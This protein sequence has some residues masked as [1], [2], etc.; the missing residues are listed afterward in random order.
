LNTVHPTRNVVVAS[1]AAVR[2]G[3]GANLG[4]K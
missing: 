2:A 1:A 3:M 4:V